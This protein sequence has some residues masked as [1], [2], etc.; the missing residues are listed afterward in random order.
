[1]LVPAF[2]TVYF[3][4]LNEVAV[5]LFGLENIGTYI[6]IFSWVIYLS[7]YSFLAVKKDVIVF[8][9]FFVSILI[10]SIASAILMGL[11]V[12]LFPVF[13]II[14]LGFVWALL[15]NHVGRQ[16]ERLI[17][18]V[19]AIDF[20]MLPLAVIYPILVI[21]VNF[22][23]IQ[24]GLFIKSYVG[25]GPVRAAFVFN[26]PV[27]MGLYFCLFSLIRGFLFQVDYKVFIYLVASLA[28]LSLGT[29]LIW[30]TIA[31]YLLVNLTG[32]SR[33]FF[34]AF[35]LAIGLVLYNFVGERISLAVALSDGSARQRIAIL[36]AGFSILQEYPFGVGWGSGA[37]LLRSHLSY[38]KSAV[39][40]EGFGFTSFYSL[41]AAELGVF[42]I[43]ALI[44]CIVLAWARG[45][46]GRL[47]SLFFGL[48]FLSSAKMAVPLI[49]VALAIGKNINKY[50]RELNGSVKRYRLLSN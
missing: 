38:F 11:A 34:I 4:L 17:K 14:L 30:I 20:Y 12:S 50:S 45:G 48:F 40:M 29:Y 41:V 32:S 16:Q 15:T 49:V 28:S 42:G 10:L 3:D 39:W 25:S 22:I 7:N 35:G 26:E 13:K 46:H 9:V 1:M 5:L 31:I 43:S 21:V 36:I 8:L 44:G 2:S 47:F 24:N 23:E 37:E 27:D 19:Q 18:L 6:F 33:L